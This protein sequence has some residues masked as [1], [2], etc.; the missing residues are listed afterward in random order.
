MKKKTNTK[1]TTR[2]I[3]QDITN[4]VIEALEKG[5]KPW[6]C[7]WDKTI[8][9]S[10]MPMNFSTGN[11]YRGINIMLLWLESEIKEYRSPNWL[12]F[13]QAKDLGGNVKKGE[14]GTQIVKYKIWEKTD[15]NDPD[16]VEKIPMI[17]TFTVFN[18]DQIEG[19]EFP[20]PSFEQKPEFE[21]LADA[22]RVIAN[23]G[24]SIQ[25]HGVKAFFTPFNDQ[26]VMP[27]PERFKTQADYY[28]TLLHELT[29]WTGRANR[30][31]R[32]F[33]ASKR[34]NDY[35]FEELV[36]E[37]GS[38]FLMAELGIKG[39]VQHES[40]IGEW[41]SNL[42]NDKKF[43]FQAASKASKAFEFIMSTSKPQEADKA[44]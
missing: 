17:K 11:Q 20:T 23:T 19:I 24:A 37:L 41:L 21:R 33:G 26:I 13:K 16:R 44:A 14:K 31:N 1:K 29:H 22:D 6:S 8:T 18:A 7:P 3:H 15:E 27:K 12:T 36:A 10:A 4:K 28:A 2:D 39:D 5:Y 9:D 43:I 32:K 42:R 30:L 35:A 25:H 34:T 38:A 40:Y